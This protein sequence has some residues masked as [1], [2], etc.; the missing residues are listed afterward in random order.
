MSFRSSE[1]ITLNW[2]WKQWMKYSFTSEEECTPL[3][4]FPRRL[5]ALTV[6]FTRDHKY[7]FI[8][9]SGLFSHP[10]NMETSG[11]YII[12]LHLIQFCV[13]NQGKCQ[14]LTPYQ[15]FALELGDHGDGFGLSQQIWREYEAISRTWWIWVR[16]SRK[17]KVESRR[18]DQVSPKDY[19][20]QTRVVVLD[21]NLST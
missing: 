20:L 7:A 13:F 12:R 1:N 11:I 16:T 6:L 19:S 15:P 5:D 3:S 8:K 4:A 18:E 21:G 17:E 2:K 9:P 14:R 10:S